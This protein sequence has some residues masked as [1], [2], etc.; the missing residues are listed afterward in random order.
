LNP[1]YRPSENS[2][3]ALLGLAATGGVL[4]L[5]GLLVAPGEAWAGY[6]IGFHFVVGVALAGAMFVAV[7]ALSGGRWADAAARVPRVMAQGL[8]LAAGLALVLCFGIPSLY[9]WSH[10]AAVEHDALLAFKAPFLN[11]SGF[12]LRTAVI[13]AAWIAASRLLLRRSR[14]GRHSKRGPLLRAAALFMAVFAVGFSVASVDWLESLDP[15]WFSTIFALYGLAGIGVSGIAVAILLVVLLRRAGALGEGRHE[16]LLDDL[17]K[18]AL[19]LS[20]FWAYIWYCQYM[21]IW[22]TN[23]PEETGWYALRMRGHWQSLAPACLLLNW[24]IPFLVL[25][26]R[27]VRRSETALIRIAVVMLLG[28]ALDLYVVVAPAIHPE[29]PLIGPWE[30][31]PIVACLA[32]G[33]LFLV[34]ALGRAQVKAQVKAPATVIPTPSEAPSA[35]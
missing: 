3:R 33:A 26:I 7:L 15:R 29:D 32:L 21:L 34:R 25:M 27:R 2:Q 35:G 9:E 22:Y 16:A 10:A 12:V 5:I 17:G 14:E 23:M 31:G 30:L 18:V 1:T 24:A 19:A 8:P 13:F 20:L 11:T 6:L 28:H 4:F